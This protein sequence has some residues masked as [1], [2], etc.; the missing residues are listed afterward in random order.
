MKKQRGYFVLTLF[1]TLVIV[2]MILIP[3]QYILQAPSEEV[4]YENLIGLKTADPT[5]QT[6]PIEPYQGRH[7]ARVAG[8]VLFDVTYGI[9]QWGRRHNPNNPQI[10]Q[11]SLAIF[12]C[13]MVF[14]AGVNDH[15]TL[16]SFLSQKLDETFVT[17]YAFP[18]DGPQHVLINLFE[19][20]FKEELAITPAIFIYVAFVESASGHAARLTGSLAINR[21]WLKSLPFI[22]FDTN[23]NL[24]LTESSLFDEMTKVQK[25]FHSLL[26]IPLMSPIARQPWSTKLIGI[27]KEKRM[28]RFVKAVLAMDKIAKSK[29]HNFHV[30]FHPMST[31]RIVDQYIDYFESETQISLIHTR[32]K[33]YHQARFNI[34]Y[35]R[36]PNEDFNRE[37]ARELA[38][39]I[40]SFEF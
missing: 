30:V 22:D 29:G 24:V 32:R 33:Y 37:F 36:H 18:G 26:S 2:S 13:S 15:Q 19:R 35:D 14:G 8:E 21:L 5:K 20:K 3:A 25:M 7:R 11:Q 4:V 1:F 6:Y 40:P 34:P 17:T 31:D 27:S 39:N 23:K 10:F 12:G 38:Q 16:A 28:R 9:D